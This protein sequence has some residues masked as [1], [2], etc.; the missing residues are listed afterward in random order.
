MKT[1]K[2][3]FDLLTLYE[4]KKAFFLFLLILVMAFLDVLGLA[5]IMPFIAVL[6][7][8]EIIETNSILYY[9][10]QK[11]SI[12]GVSNKKDFLF[13]L[14]VVV[15]I[16]LMTSLAF[17]ALT[18]YA[19]TS[20]AMMRE[21]SLGKRLIENYLHQP[22]SWFIEQNSADLGKNILLEVNQVVDK[23]IIPSINIIVNGIVILSIFSLLIFVD[24]K[25]AIIVSLVLSLSYLLIFF[26]V[27][28][29]LKKIGLDRLKANKRRFQSLSEA[30][31]SIKELKILGLE[32]NYVNKFSRPAEIFAI[33][34]SLST[35]I[36]QV[37]RFFVEAIAFGGMVVLVL[38]LINTKGEFADIAPILALYAIA[39]YRLM[40]SFQ[41]LYA[42]FSNL[43]FSGSIL[44]LIHNDLNNLK[45]A[46]KKEDDKFIKLKKSIKLKD[47]FFSYSNSQNFT[48]KNVNLSILANSKIGIVG[49]TGSGKTTVI[50]I[51]LGLLDNYKGEL[52]IDDILIDDTNKRSWQKNIGYVPQQIFLSD[53]NVSS[54]IAFG[55]EAD[56]INHKSVE[57]AARIA[58]LHDFVT[59]NL[60]KKYDTEIG[61]NGIKLSGGQRQKIGI[62]RALYHTPNILVLD[63]ATSSL[64]NTTERIVMDAIKKLSGK[65]TIIMIAHRLET[66]KNCDNIFLFDKGQLVS[67]GKYEELL[68]DKNFNDMAS[69]QN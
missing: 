37:P 8:S 30:F 28:N 58:N 6:A 18:N 41:L 24:Y 19:Q 23:T 60:E 68:L 53:G 13:L 57:K 16:F 25:L 47:I 33:N 11:S 61:E 44:N 1:I 56:K 46:E 38:F 10:Y 9:F 67:Q 26:I 45:I 43:R 14:G 7:N 55:I 66:I 69:I 20:F 2:K 52:W 32:K 51:I 63:E 5:S 29:F 31:G 34:E 49:R 40:P 64:D 36:Y 62:A 48:L 59:N 3:I 39:G 22:Y 21:Y 27:K 17:R 50:D 65:I 54:N 4:K 15:F 12:F 42:S 35:V